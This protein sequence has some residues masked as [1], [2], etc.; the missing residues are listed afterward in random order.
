MGVL[1]SK[2]QCLARVVV[3]LVVSVTLWIPGNGVVLAEEPSRAQQILDSI[4]ADRSIRGY[5]VSV[6]VRDDVITLNGHAVDEATL[7]KVLARVKERAGEAR[8][9]SKLR[10]RPPT[11]AE[12]AK[13]A[14]KALEDRGLTVGENKPGALWVTVEEGVAYVHGTAP[15]PGHVDI[16]LSASLSVYGVR[17]VRN[18]TALPR[19]PSAGV[20]VGVPR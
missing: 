1:M 18:Y 17:D 14:N 2:H 12:M 5:S 13:L 8:I 16:A 4:R 9:V 3:G 19:Y 20:H 6:K 15:T 11:D 10:V 7:E